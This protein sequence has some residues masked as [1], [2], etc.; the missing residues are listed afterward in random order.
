M[1]WK[2]PPL[3]LIFQWI[4]NLNGCHVTNFIV[5]EFTMRRHS[6]ILSDCLHFHTE[7]NF[8]KMFIDCSMII[9]C[10]CIWQNLGAV[11]LNT[12]KEKKTFEGV[13]ALWCGVGS[14]KGEIS[15]AN[16]RF[17]NKMVLYILKHTA[18]DS[19]IIGEKPVLLTL[20]S[21]VT[22]VILM[23]RPQRRPVI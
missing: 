18:I 4:Y 22:R 7:R 13:L 21:I 16:N 23:Q 17:C 9:N 3:E 5:W 6:S 19:L 11:S 15:R 1:M 8:I 14:A 10:Y 12:L 2:K 20:Y